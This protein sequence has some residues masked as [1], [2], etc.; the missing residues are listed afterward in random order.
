MKCIRCNQPLNENTNFCPACGEDQRVNSLVEKKE[1]ASFLV[2]LCVLTIIG[3][4]FTMARAFLYE[5]ISFSMDEHNYLRG[6]IYAGTSI[7]TLVG[8]IMM[9]QRKL[10][11]LHI[12]SVAQIIYI[13]T[14]IAAAFSYDDVFGSD[15]SLIALGI[16]MFFVIPSII[17]LILYWTNMVKRHLK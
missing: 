12:Y 8:A 7:G 11:G 5:I 4:A 9:L 14:V 16:G 2:V 6:W 3:S 15:A 1:N 13:L 10:I 17:F